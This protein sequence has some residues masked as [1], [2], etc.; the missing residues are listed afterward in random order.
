[1]GGV[2]GHG[3]P[4]V[5]SYIVDGGLVPVTIDN[6]SE[7]LYVEPGIWVLHRLL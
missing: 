5:G 3:I 4:R 1:M 2:D 6:G 7:G